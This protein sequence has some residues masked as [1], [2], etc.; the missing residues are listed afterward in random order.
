MKE[1]VSKDFPFVFVLDYL[2]GHKGSSLTHSTW[3]VILS[4]LHVSQLV[5]APNANNHK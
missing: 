4:I 5:L 3:A 2:L 1:N